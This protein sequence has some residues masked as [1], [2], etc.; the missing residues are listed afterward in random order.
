VS[1]KDMPHVGK[2]GVLPGNAPPALLPKYFKVKKEKVTEVV[3]ETT[4]S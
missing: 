4:T 1:L 3:L 2:N